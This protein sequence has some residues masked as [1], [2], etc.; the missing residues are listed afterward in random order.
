MTPSPLSPYAVSKLAG[1]HYCRVFHL[2]YGLETV[3]LRYFNVFGPRQD[4]GSQYAAVIPKFVTALLTGE[5][6]TI[7]GDG[8]QSRDFT[9][10]DNVVQANLRSL[11]APNAAGRVF[12]VACQEATTLNQMLR[13]LQDAL[14]TDVSPDY[15]P[16]RPGDVKHSVA[17]ISLARDLLGYEPTVTVEDGLRRTVRYLSEQLSRSDSQG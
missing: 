13:V 3:S 1:E 7:Y 6:L 5:P 15:A 2:V 4:P 9:F 14:G 16:A 10:V 11:T 12:N 8:E 17:D